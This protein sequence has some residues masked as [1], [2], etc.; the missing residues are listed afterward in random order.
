MLLDDVVVRKIL[1][2]CTNFGLSYCVMT[3]VTGVYFFSDRKS[4][5][6]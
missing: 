2:K 3:A 6:V 1:A 5:M 4:I